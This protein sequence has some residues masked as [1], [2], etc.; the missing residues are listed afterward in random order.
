MYSRFMY[1]ALFT[2]FLVGNAYGMESNGNN[3]QDPFENL[4]NEEIGQVLAHIQ[5]RDSL[6]S[7]A[8]TNQR[9]ALIVLIPIRQKKARVER[10]AER[11]MT[12]RRRTGPG[13]HGNW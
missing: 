5:E 2:I 9:H 12:C 8:L 10:Q 7:F 6:D 11:I 4:A 1:T 13:G 3:N